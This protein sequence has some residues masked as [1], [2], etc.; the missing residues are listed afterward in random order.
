M[1]VYFGLWWL[2]PPH[3]HI[4]P[5][6]E[7][8]FEFPPASLLLGKIGLRGKRNERSVLSGTSGF[9]VRCPEGQAAAPVAV[10][11][12]LSKYKIARQTAGLRP[13]DAA[14]V[15]R[16]LNSRKGRPSRPPGGHW[17]AAAHGPRDTA[18]QPTTAASGELCGGVR[19]AT[20]RIAPLHEAR[21]QGP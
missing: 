6:S 1:V 20:Q 8:S 2:L 14:G 17:R 4:R 12:P 13:A 3:K 16:S 7:Y 9:A 18:A 15:V 19:G 21:G 11:A 10:V 5:S